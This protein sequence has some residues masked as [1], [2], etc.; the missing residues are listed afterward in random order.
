MRIVNI[1]AG[2]IALY[3]VAR[4]TT[5]CIIVRQT[6]VA[7]QSLSEQRTLRIL[8]VRRRNWRD[9]FLAGG[10]LKSWRLSVRWRDRVKAKERQ[11]ET[12]EAAGI[13]GHR[14][15]RRRG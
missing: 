5:V 15:R 3:I 12:Y 11:Q 6:L 7:E 10:G 4:R 8:R 9:G 13:Y 2:T 14:H 1:G